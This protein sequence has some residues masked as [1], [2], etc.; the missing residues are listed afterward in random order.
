MVWSTDNWKFLG[1][2]ISTDHSYDSY[3]NQAEIEP[4]MAIGEKKHVCLLTATEFE[5]KKE[6]DPHFLV[7]PLFFFIL[8]HKL[9]VKR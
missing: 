4:G 5:M 7:S 8:L 2:S 3:E 1:I 9:A 6:E